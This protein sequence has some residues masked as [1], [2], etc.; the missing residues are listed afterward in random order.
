MASY[1]CSITILAHTFYYYGLCSVHA[2][3]EDI[4]D[5]TIYLHPLGGRGIFNLGLMGSPEFLTD[6]LA[7]WLQ[8]VDQVQKARVSTWRRLVEALGD[9]QVG[10]NGIASKMEQDKQLMNKYKLQWTYSLLLFTI[11]QAFILIFS[12]YLL[13]SLLAVDHLCIHTA[14]LV[15]FAIMTWFCNFRAVNLFNLQCSRATK[16]IW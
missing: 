15:A 6:K 7:E 13:S 2:G 12:P 10:Q 4:A 3:T 5:I 14:L 1:S 11:F 9:P 8:R 16:I